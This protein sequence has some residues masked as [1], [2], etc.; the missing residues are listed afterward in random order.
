MT[1]KGWNT[2]ALAREAELDRRELKKILLGQAPLTVADLFRLSEALEMTPEKLQALGFLTPESSSPP[3]ASSSVIGL[4][5]QDVA[6]E[7]DEWIPDPMGN[8]S[9]QLI[10]LGYALGCDFLLRA[11]TADLEDSGI[12]SHVLAQF[13]PLIP[14]QLD[15]EYHRY[16]KAQFHHLGLEIT[17]SFDALYTCFFPWASIQQV[18]FSPLAPDFSSDESSEEDPDP[19]PPGP[20]LRLVS[21]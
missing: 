21:G 19:S 20:G 7:E 8:H 14:I 10:R 6:V 9:Q 13:K 18:I 4:P 5:S 2:S 11:Q 16:H 1:E 17:L 15:A 12:P 3:N